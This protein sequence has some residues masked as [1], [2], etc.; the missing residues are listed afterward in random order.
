MLLLLAVYE[1][2]ELGIFN[3]FCFV[4]QWS[5]ILGWPIAVHPSR[6]RVWP[7]KR[8]WAK[9]ESINFSILEAAVKSLLVVLPLV[10]NMRIPLT[11]II[12][13]SLLHHLRLAPNSFLWDNEEVQAIIGLLRYEK[14]TQNEDFI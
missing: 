3:V 4:F 5:L 13:T 7:T 8:S 2:S 11:M 1:F 10:D 14:R 9:I 6:S 12:K